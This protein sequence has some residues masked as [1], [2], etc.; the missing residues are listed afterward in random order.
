[1][2]SNNDI[3]NPFITSE[4]STIVKLYP[5]QMNSDLY[6]NLKSNLKSKIINKC[7][8]DGVFVKIVQITKYDEN[9]INIE[10][11]TG[12]AEYRVS[13][14]GTLFVPL[15]N[16]LIILK[17]ENIIDNINDYLIKAGNG[18]VTCVI[19]VNSA[20]QFMRVEKKRIYLIKYNRYL[21]ENEY[22]KVLIKNK[23]IDPGDREIGLIG[24]IIDIATKDEVDKSY[25][26][27]THETKVEDI[28]SYIQF[29]EDIDYEESKKTSDI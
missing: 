4:F 9:I 23:R 10:D 26:T 29:N 1:M 17:V 16:T 8:N 18:I 15:V 24:S 14:I 22:I 12:N 13:F 7:N 21:E 19:S 5:N 11:F 28:Q 6:A 3:P 25:Y 27:L 20:M 2:A